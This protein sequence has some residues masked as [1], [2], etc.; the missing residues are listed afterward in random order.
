[1]VFMRAAPLPFGF[2]I[3]FGHALR[4]S[5]WITPNHLD[6]AGAGLILRGVT[7][8]YKGLTPSGK[9]HT[10]CFAPLKAE[11]LFVFFDFF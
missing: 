3:P 11:S 8:A 4:V 10:C 5:A 6:P 9:M 2:V 7:L 1:M